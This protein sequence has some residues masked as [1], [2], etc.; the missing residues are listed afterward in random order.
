MKSK[1]LTSIVAMI[2]FGASMV[3]PVAAQ[4]TAKPHRPHQYHHYQ[5]VDVGTFGGPNSSFLEGM[6]ESRMLNESGTAVGSGDTP[7]P[8]PYCI[9][10]DFDC[11]VAYGFKWQDGVAIPL[12]ALPGFNGLNS[13][14][15]YWVSDSGLTAGASENGL[16][17]LTG[18]PAVEAVLWGTDN[19]LTDLGTLGG[20]QSSA[21]AVN[22]GGQVAGEAL[23]TIPDLYTSNSNNFFISGA[24]QV[25][26]FRWTKSRGMQDL[27]TLGGTD[28][29]AFSIN[30]R[31]QIAGW[32]FT[33]TT[34]NPASGDC[35][36][37][38]MNVPT[39]DPFLWENGKMID[40]GTL[41]GT[42]GQAWAINN[43][44]Q[45]V[46]FSDL[47]DNTGAHAFLWDRTRGMQDLGS[48]G[49]DT[50]GAVSINDAG[51][52]VGGDSRADGSGGSFLWSHGVMTDLGTVGTAS[53]SVALGINSRRQIVGTL[54]DNY[55]N[56]SGG[57]L[58]ENG[59]P[60]VDLST[61]FPPHADLQLEHAYYVNDRGE[62]AA[63][64]TFSNG[65]TH[66]FVLIP[67]DEK[68]PGVEGCDYSLVD[69]STAAQSA[70]PRSIPNSTPRSVHPW[71]RNRLQIPAVVGGAAALTS[72]DSPVS[73]FTR[74]P[75]FWVAA[76]PLAPSPVNPGGSATSS[77]TAG[78]GNGIATVTLTCSVQPAPA[79][80][81]TC[82]ISPASYTFGGTPS[83]LIVSTVGP[84]GRLLSQ[85]G[86]GVLYALWLPIV[87]LVGTGVGLGSKPNGKK[88][89]LKTALLACALFPGLAFQFGCGG[90]GSIGTPAGT[91]SVTVTATGFIPVAST[92]SLTMLT[93]Q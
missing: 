69:A 63:R 25:H 77:V 83:T 5:V 60:M 51:D 70:A 93:V 22:S 34:P 62:I 23:N 59:G 80:A 30:E 18:G 3:H 16:D 24:T 40:L 78:L 1:R 82:S 79:L 48:L 10:F 29:A 11:Y 43:R 4:D 72:A 57:F 45:V 14:T 7:T 39:E 8:D 58:W 37:H 76:T 50:G 61:L 74:P 86:S 55:G 20:N 21:N 56:E 71:R 54:F 9:N 47:G 68:H 87:G 65:D 38:T 32:S 75:V 13:A 35:S 66:A 33:N 2:L 81:P 53:G 49:G 27:G 26:A 44:G 88:R 6:P 31:G 91:Y 52:V 64:G 41:G 28:S 85:P 67:C 17:P 92:S 90:K 73:D 36:G 19:S 42:C 89:K 12:S 84:S 46:G 15:G